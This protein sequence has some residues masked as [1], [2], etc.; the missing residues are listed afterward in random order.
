MRMTP[1][2]VKI[3]PCFPLPWRER[4]C[5]VEYVSILH[6]VKVRVNISLVGF[7]SFCY[8]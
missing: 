2:F 6:R 5:P 4:A 7:S 1:F 8:T 3:Y